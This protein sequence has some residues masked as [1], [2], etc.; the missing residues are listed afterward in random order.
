M[1]HLHEGHMST[2]EIAFLLGYDESNSIHRAFHSWTG[3]TPQKV[4]AAAR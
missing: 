3:H 4:R 2:T 1:N